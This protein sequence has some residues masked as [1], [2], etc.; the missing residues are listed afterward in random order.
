MLLLRN[1]DQ[2]KKN[3][4]PSSATQWSISELQGCYCMTP[5][6]WT[7]LLCSVCLTGK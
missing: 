5:G 1:K 7:W 2:Q 6:P 4:L 3:P